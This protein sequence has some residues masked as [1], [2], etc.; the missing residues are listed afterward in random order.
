[1]KFI[2]CENWR[3]KYVVEVRRQSMR[4]FT[5]RKVNICLCLS[6][7]FEEHGNTMH[8]YSIH[9][10]LANSVSEPDR[11]QTYVLRTLID[12]TILICKAFACLLAVAV[13]DNRLL[14]EEKCL[15][16]RCCC[17]DAF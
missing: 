16:F 6:A 15:C 12:R 5:S 10:I 4:A 8:I 9:I 3:N 14:H 13:Y 2:R 1:M 11:N 17:A 7:S